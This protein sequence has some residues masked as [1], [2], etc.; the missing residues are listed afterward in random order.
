MGNVDV[1]DGGLLTRI[2]ERDPEALAA[3]YDRYRGAVMAFALRVL[4]DRAEAE[5]AVG[6]I[7]HREAHRRSVP[8]SEPPSEP[9]RLET[10]PHSA[11]RPWL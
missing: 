9:S 5:E 6:E 1:G 7:R 3:L 2:V 10:V 11:R 4:R 8:S